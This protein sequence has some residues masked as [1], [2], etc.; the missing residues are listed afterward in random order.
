MMD[1]TLRR[2]LVMTGGALVVASALGTSFAITVPQQESGGDQQQ[3][4]VSESVV[5]ASDFPALDTIRTVL[6]D[7]VSWGRSVP[8]SF[9]C[10]APDPVIS[11]TKSS[12]SATTGLYVMSTGEGAEA[13]QKVLSCASWSYTND[14]VRVAVLP[15]SGG[16]VRIWQ[17]GDVLASLSTQSSADISAT[18]SALRSALS[19]VCVNM[20][21]SVEDA[22]RNPNRSDY[23]AYTKSE[24]V[25]I[26]A[27]GTTIPSRTEVGT[28]SDSTSQSLPSGL[29]GPPEPTPVTK[30]AALD[31]PGD[32]PLSKVVTVPAV[33]SVG[34]GCGW[35]FTDASAPVV[36]ESAIDATA[37]KL[38]S[39]AKSDLEAAQAKWVKS[40]TEFNEQYEDW[41]T[42]RDTWNAY[43]AEL[44]SVH[45]KWSEQETLLANYQEALSEWTAQKKVRDDFIAA[46]EEARKDYEAQ[47]AACSATSS[48]TPTPSATPAS[49]PTPTPT[50]SASSSSVQSC[51]ATVP[52]ILSQAV[53]SL[54]AKPSAP[55]L[56]TPTN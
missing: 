54:S 4:S 32:E 39:Q 16:Q 43:A 34:P 17:R 31:Y 2:A 3:S 21:P 7:D 55:T 35:A 41:A 28:L 11:A 26:A 14:D 13:F 53:P 33:D 18:D 49:T 12:G 25:T 30:P 56:W 44:D 15:L 23:T 38:K 47:V 5:E 42:E 8:V 52:Q 36:D 50:S 10:N 6:G 48:P 20:S 9:G 19:N 1:F 51:P 22:K 46:Q 27:S 37:E 40:A 45:E 24:T 29:Q